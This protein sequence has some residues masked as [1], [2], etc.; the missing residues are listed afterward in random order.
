[1]YAELAKH[2][3]RVDAVLLDRPKAQTQT[4][5]SGATFCK[6]FH[7]GRASAI[8]SIVQRWPLRAGSH[9]SMGRSEVLGKAVQSALSLSPESGAPKRGPR[10]R[11]I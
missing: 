5:T 2:D 7:I 4:H 11:V 1:M 9:R 8:S 10:S 3:F 6:Y